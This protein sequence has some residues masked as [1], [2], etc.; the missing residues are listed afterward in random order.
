MKPLSCLL[1]FLL[2]L[3]WATF[4]YPSPWAVVGGLIMLLGPLLAGLFDER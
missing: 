4:L 1:V 2:G 3:A